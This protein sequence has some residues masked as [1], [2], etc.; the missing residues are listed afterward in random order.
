MDLSA[1]GCSRRLNRFVV[2]DRNR[3]T[4]RELVAKHTDIK[5]FCVSNRMYA[6]HRR[7]SG[8]RQAPSYIELSGIPR[9]YQ[10]C[11]LVP[12]EAEFQFVST[13]LGH[14]VPAVLSSLRQWT[15]TGQDEITAERARDLRQ[16]LQET[17]RVLEEARTIIFMH[18]DRAE[19]NLTS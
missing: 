7:R 13:F 5:V 17:R 14:R 1:Y 6:D 12:A 10:Y 3:R 18:R 16:V 4:T 11:Q 9:L 19:P 8:R 2:E 15:L